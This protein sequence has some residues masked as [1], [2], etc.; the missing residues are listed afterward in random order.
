MMKFFLEP[1]RIF[2]NKP[3]AVASG[4][5]NHSTTKLDTDWFTVTAHSTFRLK[6]STALTLRLSGARSSVLKI[7]MCLYVLFKMYL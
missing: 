3:A 1:F 6:S 2:Q 4:I 7:Y 5:G